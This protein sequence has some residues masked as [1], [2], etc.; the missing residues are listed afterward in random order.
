MIRWETFHD[1]QVSFKVKQYFIFELR[2]QGNKL[3]HKIRSS[4][5]VPISV[6]QYKNV[7]L[8]Q[9]FV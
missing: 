2:I 8:F 7:R 4:H 6:Y 5:R 1:R 9:S 3:I